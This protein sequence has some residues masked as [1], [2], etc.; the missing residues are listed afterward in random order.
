MAMIDST[1]GDC[2]RRRRREM[3]NTLGHEE[4]E[5]NFL[6][7]EVKDNFPASL[8]I[9]VHLANTQAFLATTALLHYKKGKKLR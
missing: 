9:L 5:E 2:A 4:G 3:G 1:N 8:K 6:K 7:F